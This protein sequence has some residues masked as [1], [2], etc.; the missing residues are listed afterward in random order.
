MFILFIIYYMHTKKNYNF[1]LIPLFYNYFEN[2]MINQE[3]IDKKNIDKKKQLLA[4]FGLDVC[5][6]ESKN[7]WV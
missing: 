1:Y 2:I 7:T 5:K 3:N 4:V 6:P